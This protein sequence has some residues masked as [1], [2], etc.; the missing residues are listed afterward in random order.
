MADRGAADIFAQAFTLLASSKSKEEIAK[1]LWKAS[2]E[3]D[4]TPCQMEAD[5]ALEKLGL[6]RRV[7]VEEEAEYTDGTKG[8]ERYKTTQYRRRDLRSW[9]DL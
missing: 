5:R 8:V 9:D 7:D 4:F 6:A 2:F 1:E 3:F